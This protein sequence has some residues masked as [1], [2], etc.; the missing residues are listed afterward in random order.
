MPKHKEPWYSGG[1][2]FG[3]LDDCSLCCAGD[4]GHVLMTDEE[5]AAIAS[6]L[7]LTE[8]EFRRRYCRRVG[9]HLSFDQ[10]RSGIAYSLNERSNGDCVFLDADGQCAVYEVRPKQCSSY[11]FW[12]EV[13]V[14]QISWEC[15]A[16]EC[17]GMNQGRLYSLEEINKLLGR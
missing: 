1:L 4:A 16:K 2:R 5:Q 10:C 15:E 7:E 11:P 3:C 6:F 14:S 9:Q 13:L 17:P 8:E 12:K